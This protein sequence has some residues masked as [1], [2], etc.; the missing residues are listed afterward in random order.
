MKDNSLL[1]LGGIFALLLG[2]I[3]VVGSL[4]YLVLPAN[5]RAEVP[6]PVFLPAFASNPTPLMILFW[7]EA[8]VGILGLGFVPALVAL[9]KDQNEGWISWGRNLGQFGFAISSVGYLLSIARLPTIAKA[10]VAG[11]ASTQAAL[12]ATWKASIDLTGVWGYAAV[13]AFIL[14]ASLLALRGG[15][16]PRWVGWLGVVVSI[17]HFM[18]PLGAYFKIQSLLIGAVIIALLLPVWYIAVG[19]V[20]RGRAKMG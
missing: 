11:D 12:A 13:G 18:V 5:L 17:P 10:Y 19:L 1:K 2:V 16:L 8:L 4:A 9:V 7:E 14:I 6:G 20:M 15:A 3:K